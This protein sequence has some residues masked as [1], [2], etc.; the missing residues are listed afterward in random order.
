MS[1]KN[2]HRGLT[3]KIERYIYSFPTGELLPSEQEMAVYFEFSNPTLRLA[4]APM[5]EKRFIET[6]N[7]VGS[8]VR[9]HPLIRRIE[10]P[11]L[12]ELHEKLDS[13]LTMT[14]SDTITKELPD[15]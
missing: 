6:V 8:R 12:V 7:G 13:E 5:I 10:N 1:R 15:S 3:R 4:L 9:K 2:I 14:E 11:G